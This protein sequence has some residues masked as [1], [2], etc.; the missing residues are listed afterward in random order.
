MGY[1]V[2]VLTIGVKVGPPVV[3]KLDGL[4]KWL[5]QVAIAE[6]S[7]FARGVR[8][9]DGKIEG[10]QSRIDKGCRDGGTREYDGVK[11]LRV[12][13][14]DAICDGRAARVAHAYDFLKR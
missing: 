4:L 13:G 12:L 10:C 2:A 6:A 5:Y 7:K 8:V 3:G 1:T 11:V 14:G 9:S